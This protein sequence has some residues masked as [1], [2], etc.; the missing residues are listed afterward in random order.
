MPVRHATRRFSGMGEFLEEW[1]GTLG[2]GA[3]AIRRA[4]L[5]D[6]P[7]PE[8]KLDLLLPLVGRVGP[9]QAQVV[10]QGPDG[11]IGLR[12]SSLPPNVKARIDGLLAAAREVRAHLV[13]RGDVVPAD[14]VEAR[15]AQEERKRAHLERRVLAGG[16]SAS[17]VYA[18]GPRPRGHLVPD[19][20][21]DEPLVD[22]PMG[23][24]SLRDSLVEIAIRRITGLLVV[25][26]QEG[27]RWFGL[28]HRGGPVGFRS[29]PV[30]PELVLGM[31]LF[32]ARRITQEQ[33]AQSLRLMEEQGIRQ[34][35]ALIQMGLLSFPQLVLLLQKQVEA[36]LQRVMRLRDG[37]WAFFGLEDLPERFVNPPLQVPS[38]FLR[39]LAQH[40]RSL[41]AE[42]MAAVHRPNLDRY[43]FVAPDVDLVLAEI[44]FTPQEKKFL[45]IVRS[46][47]WRLRELFSRS[48][49]SRTETSVVVFAL[50][51]MG[52]LE[53]REEETRERY[54]DRIGNRIRQKARL[55]QTA[56]HFE[57]LEIHWICLGEEVAE[58]AARVRREY[59]PADFAHLPEDLVVQLAAIR[60]AVD[61][62]LAFLSDD[63]RRRT[64]RQEV[65]EKAKI[66]GSAEILGRKGEMA[67]LKADRKEA[68]LCFSKAVE[69]CPLVSAYREG[70]ERASR[71]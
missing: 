11:T 10:S 20:S 45:E 24:R 1:E 51:E 19:V 6:D 47:A 40:A 69:L 5:D 60:E 49:L 17:G 26:T 48:N 43:V 29:E 64:Y 27:P 2:K 9:V 8:I 33:L 34:G 31:L 41:S 67:L 57:I 22:G 66:E 62:S 30:D 15:L 39:A 71:L 42:D 63:K 21:E 36:A 13:A 32:R 56:T 50:N 61:T 28:W 70:L 7:A 37:Y 25:V 59:D 44:R 14:L 65:V 68:M 4:D 52:F 18:S 35:E 54:L 46:N 23:D 12:L 58:G 16:A 38:I 55:L 3:L 53:Y